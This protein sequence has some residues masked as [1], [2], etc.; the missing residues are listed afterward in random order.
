MPAVRPQ[1]RRR[2]PVVPAAL[3]IPCSLHAETLL[4][5]EDGLTILASPKATNAPCPLGGRPSNRVHSRYTRT[6][7]DLPW[8]TLA[9]RLRVAVR[10]FFC[11][12]PACPRRIFAERVD[13]VAR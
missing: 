1:C 5:A 3:P 11:D 4:L 7:A 13:G 12:Q 8:A 10:E 2:C 9:V 6:L